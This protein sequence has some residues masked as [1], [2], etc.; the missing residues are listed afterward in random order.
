MVTVE[1]VKK[2][3]E[4][5]EKSISASEIAIK[6]MAGRLRAANERI[7]TIVSEIATLKQERQSSLV[8]GND[9][10]VFSKKIRALDYEK[11]EREEEI[12]GLTAQVGKL[13][14]EVDR[15]NRQ[16]EMERIKIKQIRTIGLA[17]QYNSIA[18]QIAKVVRELNELNIELERKYDQKNYRVVFCHR[19]GAMERIPKMFFDG[20]ELLMLED[21]P[22]K[23]GF[24]PANLINSDVAQS[25]FYDAK[26]HMPGWF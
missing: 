21:Y 15:S 26:L 8:A 17:K 4:K 2:E 18:A 24:S 6:E 20:D 9:S 12:T 23:H 25:C 1:D 13:R 7:E 22:E 5:H 11:E 3:I 16:I 19:N 10:I 14:A